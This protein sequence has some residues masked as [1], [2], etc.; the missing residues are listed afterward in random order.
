M[1]QEDQPEIKKQWTGG[2]I[3]HVSNNGQV[4]KLDMF[5]TM[6]RWSS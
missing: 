1:Q 5:L 4:V 3:R 6:D 2:Q